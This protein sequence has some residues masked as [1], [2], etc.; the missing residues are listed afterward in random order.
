ME[1]RLQEQLLLQLQLHRAVLLMSTQREALEHITIRFQALE[2]LMVV[3]ITPS[4]VSQQELGPLHIL[5][6]HLK[7]FQHM[8]QLNHKVVLQVTP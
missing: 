1:F 8:L 2:Q 7:A 4:Q 3:M 6:D 5:A